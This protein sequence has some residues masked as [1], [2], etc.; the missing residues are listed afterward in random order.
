MK[1]FLRRRQVFQ[2]QKKCVF[3]ARAPPSKKLYWRR[4]RLY[5]NFEVVQRKM[6][7]IK[8][9]KTRIE[10]EAAAYPP[11]P[12]LPLPSARYEPDTNSLVIFNFAFI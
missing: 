6:E 5:K 12:P 4:S 10:K 3:S 9:G 8:F 2:K 7:V 11:P 1:H